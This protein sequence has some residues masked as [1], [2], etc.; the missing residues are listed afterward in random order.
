[1]KKIIVLTAFFCFNTLIINAQKK[2]VH[3][4]EYYVIEAQNGKKW[5]ADDKTIDAK[6]KEVRKKKWK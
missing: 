3:D 2:I 1:M 6:L 4:A 5:A